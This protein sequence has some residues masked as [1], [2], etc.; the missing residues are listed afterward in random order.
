MIITTVFGTRPEA[1]KLCPVIAELRRRKGVRVTVCVTGQ[2]R[3]MLE[4]VLEVFGVIPDVDLGVMTPNQSLSLLSARLLEG[5]DLA[6]AQTRSDLVVVQGD[7]TTALM[8]TLAAFYRRV[9]V[10]TRGGRSA[11]RQH[12]IALA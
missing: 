7:T 1:I 5:L 4:Q 6:L 8:G 12:A 2:H 11:D 3:Q 9:P 10:S